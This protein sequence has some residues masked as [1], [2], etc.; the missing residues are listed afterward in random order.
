MLDQEVL[1]AG[2]FVGIISDD[3]D[4]RILVDVGAL[5]IV[6]ISDDS[7]FIELGGFIP[8]HLCGH[9]SVQQG[10]L[11]SSWIYFHQL[12]VSDASNSFAGVVCAWLW[13]R[14]VWVA[15]F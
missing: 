15:F 3:E 14:D 5:I 8:I 9:W 1:L 10:L 6:L 2:C 12:I 7:T 4:V 11:D 13:L